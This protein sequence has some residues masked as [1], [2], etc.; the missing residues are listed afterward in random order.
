MDMG[1]SSRDHAMLTALGFRLQSRAARLG[2][3]AA[4]G[5]TR[6]LGD[7][8]LAQ[9]D[10]VAEAAARVAERDRSCDARRPVR[11]KLGGPA[12]YILGAVN[13]AL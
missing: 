3:A 7:G 10:E 13:A 9:R 2:G 8:L 1:A 4:W 6:V 11:R 12:L 5:A